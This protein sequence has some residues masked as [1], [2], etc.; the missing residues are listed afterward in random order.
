[1]QSTAGDTE[2]LGRRRPVSVVSGEG[3][4]QIVAF[5][6]FEAAFGGAVGF[7]CMADLM[8]NQIVGFDAFPCMT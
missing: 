6:I 2:F 3:C 8:K 5:S 4:V 7:G 1:M